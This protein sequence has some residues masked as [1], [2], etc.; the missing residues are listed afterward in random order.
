MHTG[1]TTFI[2]GTVLAAVATWA[3]SLVAVGQQMKSAQPHEMAMPAP[4]TMTKAQK[5]ADAMTAAPAAISS[6]ATI[7]DW[8]A[9]EGEKPSV[10]RAGSNGWSCLPDM[11]ETKG[12]D[13]MCLDQPWMKW[14]DAY[15]AKTA[16]AGGRVG[17]GYIIAPGGGMGSDTDPYAMAETAGNHWGLHKPHEMIVVPDL[18]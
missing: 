12:N 7:L 14:V 3:V 5:I 11:P 10:L 6:K 13:P 9:K 15:M 4:S 8:P 16:P 18:L 17:I 1:K 2:G